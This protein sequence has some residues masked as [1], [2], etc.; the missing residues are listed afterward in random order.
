MT[1]DMRYD[2]VD[3]ISCRNPVLSIAITPTL[4]LSAVVWTTFA[5]DTV[6]SAR[7]D[8]L[9]YA[10][11]K[12]TA[13]LPNGEIWLIAAHKTLQQ[14]NRITRYNG[15]WKS[16]QKAGV[17][18][19]QGEFIGES[20]LKSESGIR[21]FGAVRC[22]LDQLQAIHAVMRAAQA[23]LVVIPKTQAKEVVKLLVKRGWTMTNSKPP[24][25]VLESVC[26]QSGLVVEVYGDF[27]D[28]EVSVSAIGRK[29]V[30]RNLDLD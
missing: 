14:D 7:L 8:C 16:L 25:E 28:P 9:D 4:P 6:S 22:E 15:L 3:D 30:F 2:F 23:A 29:E 18:I 26:A 24:E 19:P 11:Q 17:V 27:D 13:N 12:L 1:T 5:A 10:L 20:V 21:I